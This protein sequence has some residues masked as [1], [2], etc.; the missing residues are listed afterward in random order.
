MFEWGPYGIIENVRD[1]WNVVFQL[2]SEGTDEGRDI[3]HELEVLDLTCEVANEMYYLK[4][5]A[6]ELG[7]TAGV[8]ECPASS[9]GPPTS[10]T[11]IYGTAGTSSTTIFRW[12]TT[13]SNSREEPQAQGI[14]RLSADVAHVAKRDPVQG[15]GEAP[16]R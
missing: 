16:D 4:L 3:S 11:G 12:R 2:F 6:K 8:R 1:G 14:D 5:M 15:A 7:D 13:A 10:S 9:G